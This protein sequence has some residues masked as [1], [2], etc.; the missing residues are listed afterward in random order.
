[1]YK[2]KRYTQQFKGA[3]LKQIVQR[4]YSFAEVKSASAPKPGAKRSTIG[5][6]N[7]MAATI[8][9]YCKSVPRLLFS[10]QNL[11]RRILARR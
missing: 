7:Y 11:I 4:G 5:G 9:Q 8:R 2:G 6:A 3:A 10:D 1:M